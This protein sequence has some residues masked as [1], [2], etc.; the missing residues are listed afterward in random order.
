M[1]LTT[2]GVVPAMEGGEKNNHLIARTAP[3][4]LCSAAHSHGNHQGVFDTGML[5]SE[6]SHSSQS[7]VCDQRQH[8]LLLCVCVG[9]SLILCQ[10]GTDAYKQQTE[11]LLPP[12]LYYLR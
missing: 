11:F 1:V 7:A 2:D 9:V 8:A 4:T 3:S 6:T 12:D 10:S 5:S